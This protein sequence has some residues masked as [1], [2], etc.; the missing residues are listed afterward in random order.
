[1][2]VMGVRLR[3]ACPDSPVRQGLVGAGQP[4]FTD[5]DTSIRASERSWSVNP[6]ALSRRFALCQHPAIRSGTRQSGSACQPARRAAASSRRAESSALPLAMYWTSHR[7]KGLHERSRVSTE[8]VSARQGRC[9]RPTAEDAMPLPGRC[10]LRL[11]SRACRDRRLPRG[12]SP[13]LWCSSTSDL[14]R[15]T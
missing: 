4:G 10:R 7:V 6:I 14:A 1:M 3:D 9:A 5:I 2:A 12:R 15:S 11:R 13:A 8:I